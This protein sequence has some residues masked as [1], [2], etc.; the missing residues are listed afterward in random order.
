MLSIR[1]YDDCRLMNYIDLAADS[2]VEL[3]V[4]SVRVDRHFLTVRPSIIAG[5]DV[6]VEWP[7]DRNLEVAKEMAAL[8]AKHNAKTILGLQGS[9]APVMGKMKET[10]DNGVIGQVL[11][12]TLLGALSNAGPTESKNVRYFLD[13]KVGGNVMSIHGGHLLEYVTAGTYLALDY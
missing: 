10:I 8:A 2:T 3:V 4:C 6:Y 13:R 9:F 1:L 7:L 5:K 12:S 11:S